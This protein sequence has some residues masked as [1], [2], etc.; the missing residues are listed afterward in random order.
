MGSL[1]SGGGRSGGLRLCSGGRTGNDLIQIKDHGFNRGEDSGD[2]RINGGSGF[3]QDPERNG[4]CGKLSETSDQFRVCADNLAEPET[5]FSSR[6]DDRKERKSEGFAEC[7][8]DTFRSGRDPTKGTAETFFHCICSIFSCAVGVV[9]FIHQDIDRVGVHGQS[10]AAERSACVEDLFGE[11]DLFRVGH[12]LHRLRDIDEGITHPSHGAVRVQG[13]DTILLQIFDDL[14]ICKS[15]VRL[16]E[17]STGERTTDPHIRQDSEASGGFFQIGTGACRVRTS[18]FQSFAEV[19]QSLGRAV[20]CDGQNIRHIRH[21]I[22]FQVKNTQIIRGN[23]SSFTEFGI[24]NARKIHHWLNSSFN[25]FRVQV[26]P[27]E[28]QHPFRDLGSSEGCFATEPFRL[29]GKFFVS[30]SGGTGDSLD[31]SHF[32]VEI[33]I[34]FRNHCDGVSGSE[35]DHRHFIRPRVHAGGE[36]RHFRF[37]VGET[38]REAG[39]VRR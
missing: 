23:H 15:L 18:H 24:R 32:V 19:G 33:R 13:F 30:L 12:I 25:L 39:I 17:G 31:H 20:R 6:F 4:G 7:D 11:H 2:G 35:T 3:N 34:R 8:T 27:T 14:R 1:C 16:T 22:G 37:R 29:L 26:H 9:Q 10:T 38:L 5:K 28:R 21:L 36:L